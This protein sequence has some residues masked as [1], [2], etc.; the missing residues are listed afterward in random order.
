MRLL[1][2]VALVA[3]FAAVAIEAV[4]GQNGGKKREKDRIIRKGN[5]KQA[6]PS[7]GAKFFK[8]FRAFGKYHILRYYFI[9]VFAAYFVLPPNSFG[10]SLTQNPQ[11]EQGKKLGQGFW[12]LFIFFF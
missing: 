5:S 1:L 10:Q 2:L 11:K 6:N 3:I 8:Y 9:C 4:S 12:F 7:F